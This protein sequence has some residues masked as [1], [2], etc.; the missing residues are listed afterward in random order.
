MF[1]YTEVEVI[2]RANLL[3]IKETL[4]WILGK[5]LLCYQGKQ[6]NINF[7]YLHD[8]LCVLFRHFVVN[9]LNFKMENKLFVKYLG[10]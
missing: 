4:A 10:R 9:C 6:L 3:H 2:S 1:P 8:C 7:I 5:L